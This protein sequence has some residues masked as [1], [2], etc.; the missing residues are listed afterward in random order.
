M[1]QKIHLTEQTPSLLIN[2]KK[3]KDPDVIADAFNIFFL[4]ITKNLNLHKKV[5]GDAIS[6]LKEAFPTKL[7]GIKTIPMTETEIKSVIHSLK[8]KN[9]LGYD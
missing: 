3:V 6:S 2:N 9:L 7:P 1:K 4:T 8:A 5:I